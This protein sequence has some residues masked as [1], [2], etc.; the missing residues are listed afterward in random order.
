MKCA[1]VIYTIMNTVK[2]DRYCVPT[3]KTMNSIVIPDENREHSPIDNEGVVYLQEPRCSK[4][5]VHLPPSH[6]PQQLCNVVF[7]GLVV[8]FNFQC[9]VIKMLRFYF[10]SLKGRK[11]S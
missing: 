11:T 9:F 8:R 2:L 5:I 10:K 1:A 3:L 4:C 6:C 7:E